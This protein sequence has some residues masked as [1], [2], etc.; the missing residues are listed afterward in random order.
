MSTI[1]NASGLYPCNEL[2]RNKLR[3]MRDAPG[4]IWSNSKF[5]SRLGFSSGVI[6]QYLNDAGNKYR[7]D[8]T[9][10]EHRI[11]DFLRNEARR[12][13][14]GVETVWCDAAEQMKS[15]F[16]YIRRT[17]DIGA[18]VGESGEGKSRGIELIREEHPLALLFTVR[19]WSNDK[20]SMQ[21]AIWECIPHAGYDTQ[22]KRATFMVTS[23]RGSDRPLLVD[24]AHKLTRP[25]LHWLFDFYDETNIPIALFGTPDLLAKLEDDSQRFSRVGL[26]RGCGWKMFPNRRVA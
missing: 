14:S 10:L 7:A 8:V 18:I 24:D 9:G 1:E 16:E 11:D 25:A 23:M 2:L 15:A 19:A 4:S 26:P 5:G 20:N 3:E 21:S 12:R 13:A 17:N 6:S 22:T